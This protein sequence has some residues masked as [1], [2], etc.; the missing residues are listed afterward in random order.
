MAI[1]AIIT[2]GIVLA[3]AAVFIDRSD[4]TAHRPVAPI[5]D[6]HDDRGLVRLDAAQIAAAGI[7]VAAVGPA[8]IEVVARFPGEIRLDDDRTAHVVPR[9][10][11]IV[12]RVHADLGQHVQAG[13]LLASISSPTLSDHR[14]EWL[15]ATTRRDL[16]RATWQREKNLWEERISARQ[17]YLQAESA[18]HE[19]DIAVR[20]ASQKLAA[21]GARPATGALKRLEIRAP[22]AGTVVEKH[23]TRGE[24]VKE[25]TSIFTLADLS[26]VW[27][28][29][30]VPAQDLATV[31]VGQRVRVTSTAFDGQSD[32]T[33]S[34]VG[35][36][37]GEQTRTAK[38]RVVIANPDGAW[39]PGL[40]VTVALSGEAR[41]APLTVRTDAIQ[42]VDG[43]PTVFV[44][45]PD[46]FVTRPVR[47]GRSD[48][49][50]TEVLD[51]VRAGESY[52]TTN[53]FVLK[54]ELGKASAEH[55]H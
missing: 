48:G 41:Q 26:T 54:A 36:L 14:S 23:I 27:A 12:E 49:T 9:A 22:F 33:V 47:P 32:G 16:A 39:R 6:G 11:G 8:T 3:G 30:A 21:V 15:T 51:G 46:G 35:S 19:A 40:F 13:A 17:D 50:T 4:A 20:N 1:A 38:A 43:K 44:R 25:D 7:T 18:L 52:A 5:D 55:A 45:A 29:F 53:A 2:T 28:E 34:Y 42:V 31:R 37:L 10:G 24:A